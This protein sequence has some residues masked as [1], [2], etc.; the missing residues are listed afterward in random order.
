MLGIDPSMT[1]TGIAVWRRPTR[2][3]APPVTYTLTASAPSTEAP[4]VRWRRILAKVW[5][6]CAGRTLI[7]VESLPQGR[8]EVSAMFIERA[9]LLALLQYGA[10]ARNIPVAL[11]NPSTLKGY[12]TGSG[13]AGK[14]L[15]VQRCRTDLGLDPASDN[16][17]DAA[18]C[19][20]MALDH[21]GLAPGRPRSTPTLKQQTHRR[22]VR[23]PN[24]TTDDE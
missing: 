3:G 11:I 8:I 17:A 23:W 5:P 10:D 7:A 24:W 1:A 2:P 14:H 22:V 12:A 4:L 6:E 16:E 19:M 9:G 18:W 13:R 15:M 21:Y 20:A